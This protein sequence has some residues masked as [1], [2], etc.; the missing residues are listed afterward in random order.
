[1]NSTETAFN[2]TGEIMLGE[3]AQTDL[4]PIVEVKNSS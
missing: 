2:S 4:S 3:L 1:M